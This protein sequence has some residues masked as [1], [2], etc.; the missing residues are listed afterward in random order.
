MGHLLL[1]LVENLVLKELLRTQRLLWHFETFN[2][3]LKLTN[4]VFSTVLF[5]AD[6]TY[7][8]NVEEFCEVAALSARRSTNGWR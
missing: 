2:F 8:R 4:L 3:E 5:A 7:C 1:D 6:A